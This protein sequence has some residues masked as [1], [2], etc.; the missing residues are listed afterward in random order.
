L[1]A[2]ER[3]VVLHDGAVKSVAASEDELFSVCASGAA[4]LFELRT[5]EPRARWARAHDKI[6]NSA[7][8]LSGRRFASVSRDRCLRLWEGDRLLE[9]IATPHEH[10]IK[11]LA[12]HGSVIATGAYDGT[13]AF[14]DTCSRRWLQTERPTAA[15]ISGLSWDPSTASFAASSYDG[16]VYRVGS[17]HGS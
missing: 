14:Y 15:G 6:A 1:P 7:V 4:V 11:C 13:A 10:S 9:R 5:L 12:V 8:W 17:S 3:R 2:L 16:H